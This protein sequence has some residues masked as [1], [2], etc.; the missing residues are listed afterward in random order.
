[1]EGLIQLQ[2][3]CF[4]FWVD[5][6]RERRNMNRL[7]ALLGEAMGHADEEHDRQLVYSA[8]SDWYAWWCATRLAVSEKRG[9]YIRE[10]MLNSLMNAFMGK[11][12]AGI[13]NMMTNCVR[14]WWSLSYGE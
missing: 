7:K 8:F 6:T 2:A 1:M 9:K 13:T 14:E 3:E 12:K 5:N 4:H 10:K 11:D